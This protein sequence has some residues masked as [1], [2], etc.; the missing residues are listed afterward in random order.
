MSKRIGQNENDTE[1]E[2]KALEHFKPE[3]NKHYFL[4]DLASLF[5]LL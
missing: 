2:T 4:T 1:H 5:I 3:I